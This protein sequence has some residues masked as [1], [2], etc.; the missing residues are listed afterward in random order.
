MIAIRPPTSPTTLI[1]GFSLHINGGKT[2][3]TEVTLLEKER[4]GDALPSSSS[5]SSLRPFM[6]YVDYITTYRAAVRAG[7]TG[8]Y[9]TAEIW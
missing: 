2:V 6:N 9:A 7:A 5:S 8:A 3:P 4:G 1:G